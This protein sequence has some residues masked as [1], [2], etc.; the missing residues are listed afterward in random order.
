MNWKEFIASLVDSLA[1]PAS[2]AFA[3]FLLRHRL[4]DS[5]GKLLHDRRIKSLKWG[6]FEATLEEIEKTL[7]ESGVAPPL[8]EG[9]PTANGANDGALAGGQTD[10]P[11]AENEAPVAEGRAEPQAIL[12]HRDSFLAIW[13]GL[14]EELREIGKRRGYPVLRMGP[15]SIARRLVEDGVAP[16]RLAHTIRRLS[17][18]RNS[19]LHED[20]AIPSE[21]LLE[22]AGQALDLRVLLRDIPNKLFA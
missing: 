20:A 12:F 8:E 15:A 4:A 22:L 14:E 13:G 11:E 9:V 10:A 7:D 3:V 5:M 21:Q 16:P 17:L 1:W 2:I 18:A 6:R 19:V